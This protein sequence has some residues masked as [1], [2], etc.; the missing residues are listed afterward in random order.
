MEIQQEL[1]QNDNSMKSRTSNICYLR[2]YKIQEIFV[3]NSG[4]ELPET[5]YRN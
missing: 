3:Q 5:E 2:S 4:T 1:T